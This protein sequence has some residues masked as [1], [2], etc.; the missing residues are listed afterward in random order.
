[1]DAAG[2]VDPLH[3]IID[4]PV[5]LFVALFRRG[6]QISLPIEGAVGMEKRVAQRNR[7]MTDAAG[8]E[9]D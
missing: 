8:G 1:M 6:Q 9:P 4:L 3:S 7:R 2:I 5:L